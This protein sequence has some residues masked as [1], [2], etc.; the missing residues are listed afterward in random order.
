MAGA[1][2]VGEREVAPRKL[3]AVALALDAAQRAHR[4]HHAQQ[5]HLRHILKLY[6]GYALRY[7]AG[8]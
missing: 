2:L 5:V 1:P 8:A 7:Y 4:R 3:G 6:I